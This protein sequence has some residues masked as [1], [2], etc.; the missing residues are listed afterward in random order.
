LIV[1]RERFAPKILR[2]FCEDL[3]VGRTDA[4]AHLRC[5]SRSSAS[6]GGG[7]AKIEVMVLI[8]AGQVALFVTEAHSNGHL[9]MA[10]FAGKRI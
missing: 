7:N 5:R 4:V 9:A 6:E 8:D 3:S 10:T 1:I 2:K